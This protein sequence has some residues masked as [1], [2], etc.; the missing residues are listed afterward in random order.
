MCGIAGMATFGAAPRPDEETLRRMCGVMRYRGPDDEGVEVLG[1][2]GIAMRRLS[3]IDLAGGHQPIY[4]ENRTVRVVFNG[5]IYNFAALRE[6]LEKKGHVFATHTDTEV[7]VHAYEEY[8]DSF[9]V[10]LNGMF[11]IA[12]HDLRR[13]R[14]L[15]VRDHVGIKPL[16]YA[17]DGAALVWG[18]EVKVVLASG[19]VQRSLDHDALKEFISWE[20]V[21]EERTLL[22]EVRKLKPGHLIAVE[23]K[24]PSCSQACYWDVP[25]T[26]PGAR[27]P[28]EAEW[29]ERIDDQVRRSVRMQMVSDVPLGAFLSGG[30]DSSLVV[31]AMGDAHTFSIGFEDPTYN[32]LAWSGKV[33]RHLG[34][35]HT[36]EIIQPDIGGLFDELMHH[37]D[38]PIGD[39]SIFP[40]F[41]VSRL[42]RRHVTVCLSGDGGDELFG[43]Y[44]TYQADAAARRIPGLFHK[45]ASLEQWIA[46]SPAKKG[47][48]NKAKRFLEGLGHDPALGHAR[49]R[50]F[51][52]E[53]LSSHLFCHRDVEVGSA[54]RHI[55]RAFERASSRERL[56]QSLYVDFKTY[57]PDNILSKVDRMSMAVSLEARV[58][59]LDKDLVELAFRVPSRYKLHGREL[60]SILKKTAVRHVPRE[61]LYRPKQG[62]SIPI[63][64]WLKTT[65]RER[66]M[67]LLDPVRLRQ[68]GCLEASVVETM[69]RQHLDGTHNHSHLL[70]AIMVFQRWHQT[71]MEKKDT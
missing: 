44:E 19:R 63:K 43:G 60:K 61:C 64:H 55:L 23:L 53:K 38:D 35:K 8:G 9:P 22:Q 71:W 4:N 69:V 27:D 47:P 12:L 68:Q 5:E 51:A 3:I 45:A 24:A 2:V 59:L 36:T 34:V 32:E 42:A 16:Y 7:I 49:W 10:H 6:E 25:E 39:F 57:L 67:E 46:P 29:I 70:W 65:L 58:P 14:L 31:A 40:T 26:D 52:S 18:S 1:E 11:A 48:I 54:G 17:F 50:L 30:V 56:D 41:L 21:P 62:F 66:M 13:E 20:Y 33:A 28:G 37:M 15:L